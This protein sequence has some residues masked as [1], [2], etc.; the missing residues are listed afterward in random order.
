V[1]EDLIKE[2]PDVVKDL[3]R[4]IAQSGLWADTHGAEAAKVAAPY[5]RQDPK[6]LNYVLTQQPRIVKYEDL[7]PTDADLQK[8]NDMAVQ[9]G[10]LKHGVQMKD[11]IDRD[12]I[13]TDIKPADINPDEKPQVASAN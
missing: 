4:G 6:L 3:V 10:V 11:L 9:M 2:R 8:I 1:H 13:P 12:F 7:T 5:F